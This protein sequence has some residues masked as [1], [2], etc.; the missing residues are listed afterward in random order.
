MMTIKEAS[1][2]FGLSYKCIISRIRM[3]YIPGCEKR[4]DIKG[5]LVW[6][7]PDDCVLAPGRGSNNNPEKRG[8]V[9]SRQI[10]KD[11][12]LSNLSYQEKRDYIW[13]YS[14]SMPIGKL[15]RILGLTTEE[16]I[17]IYDSFF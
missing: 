15:K 17:D 3:G 13:K 2:K 7:L 5:S 11:G 1:E 6:M 4:H 10:N 12:D 14:I 8:I 16:V 9:R